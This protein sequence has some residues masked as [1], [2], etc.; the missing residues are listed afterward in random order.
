[1]ANKCYSTVPK[2]PEL[3]L[4]IKCSLV[5]YPGHFFLGGS[6]PSTGDTASLFKA[7]QTRLTT[8]Y[9]VCMHIHI[10]LC[11]KFHYLYTLTPGY[12]CLQ[13]EIEKL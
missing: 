12:V 3:K 6:Y 11:D 13:T 7:S 8:N 1:M 9:C 10:F 2:A 5:S 4:T